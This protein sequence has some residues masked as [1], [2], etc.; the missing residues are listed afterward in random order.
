M[1]DQTVFLDRDGVVNRVVLRDGKPGSPRTL[2]EFEF[3]PGIKPALTRLRDAG[4]RLFVVSNQPD[5]A[6]GGLEAAVCS[7]MTGRILDTLPVE[8]VVICS[9]DD[10]DQCECRKPK[11]GMLSSLARDRGLDLTRA[12]MIGDS[13]KD[14][15]AARAA[16]CRSIILSRDY[17]VGVEADYRVE[18]MEEAVSL[19][20]D[21]RAS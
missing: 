13:A 9:H 4:F 5:L 16:G 15:G 8:R 6:R 14:A 17:N 10:G 21:G 18:T 3:E 7:A 20:V 19:I 2:E 11:P 1:D 12:W